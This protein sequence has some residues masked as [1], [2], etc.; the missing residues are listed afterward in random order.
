MPSQPLLPLPSPRACAGAT[1]VPRK[2]GAGTSAGAGLRRGDHDM[3]IGRERSPIGHPSAIR[4][5]QRAQRS[6]LCERRDVRHRSGAL[7]ARH[8][9]RGDALQWR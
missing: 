6:H 4:D 7:E 5:V 8:L 3:G 2:A 1:A 9:E